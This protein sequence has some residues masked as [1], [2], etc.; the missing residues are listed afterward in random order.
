MGTFMSKHCSGINYG[1][2]IKQNDSIP[3]QKTNSAKLKDY[4]DRAGKIKL[5]QRVKDSLYNESE[6]AGKAVYSSKYG[7]YFDAE[8]GVLINPAGKEYLGFKKK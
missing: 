7:I 6:K 4:K 2:P 8:D 3:G 5:P 1:S